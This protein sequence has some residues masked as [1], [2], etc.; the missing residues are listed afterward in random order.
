MK[1]L[2]TL[3]LVL[4]PLVSEARD[5]NLPRKFLRQLGLTHTPKG[6]QVDHWIALKCGGPD[7]LENLRLICGDY[8][9]KKERIEL[10]CRDAEEWKKKNPC[11]RNICIRVQQLHC[12]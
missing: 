2:L 12:Q 4:L 1:L 5:T 3:I 9:I 11:E 8:K 7:T 10:R 6:C